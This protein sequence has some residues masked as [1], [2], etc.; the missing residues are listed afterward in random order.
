MGVLTAPTDS[1]NI[2]KSSRG[3][4]ESE[5]SKVALLPGSLSKKKKKKP[6]FIFMI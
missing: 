3:N 6:Q 2:A 1:E 4:F 5:E